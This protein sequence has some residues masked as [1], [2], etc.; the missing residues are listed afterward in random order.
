[1]HRGGYRGFRSPGYRG[2]REGAYGSPSGPDSGIEGRNSL[3]QYLIKSLGAYVHKDFR[4]DGGRSLKRRRYDDKEDIENRL[5]S[6]IVR[7]G[8]KSSSSLESNLQGLADALEGDIG[9][10]RDQILSMIFKWYLPRERNTNDLL[11]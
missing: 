6:L 11:S 2:S 4:R 8:D 10:H 1:M 3:M 9:H 5:N 7:I